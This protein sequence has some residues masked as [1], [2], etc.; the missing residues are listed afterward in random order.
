MMSRR[1]P[2]PTTQFMGVKIPE[3]FV[4]AMRTRIDPQDLFRIDASGDIVISGSEF[5]ETDNCGVF[6][7]VIEMFPKEVRDHVVPALSKLQPG[8]HV[9]D[10][11]HIWIYSFLGIPISNK[12]M[13]FH[14]DLLLEKNFRNECMSGRLGDWRNETFEMLIEPYSITEL[15]SE[16]ITDEMIQTFNLSAGCVFGSAAFNKR[17]EAYRKLNRKQ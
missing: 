12:R 8:S 15:Q 9:S 11:V 7:L 2:I 10:P 5:S 1:L 4:K 13:I 17:I 6:E 3:A 14:G 16:Y